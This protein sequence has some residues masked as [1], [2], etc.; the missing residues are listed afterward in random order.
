MRSVIKGLLVVGALAAVSAPSQARAD[1]FLIPWIGS[2]FSIGP[3][4]NTTVTSIK[5]GQVSFGGALGSEGGGIFGFD[6]DFGYTPKFFGDIP[7]NSNN[8]FTVMAD[9]TAGPRITSR[10]GRGV[11]PHAT[12]GVGLVHQKYSDS[13]S[14]NNFGYNVGGGITGYF[15]RSLGIRGDVRFFQ[16]VNNSDFFNTITLS[17]GHLHYWRATIGLVIH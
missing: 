16:T 7:N 4:F 11:R 12:F 8:L 15:S 1:G 17:S 5:N 13:Q 3:D 2:V 6:I 10:G 14:D 9:V